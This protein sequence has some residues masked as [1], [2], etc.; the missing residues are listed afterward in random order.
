MSDRRP[1]VLLALLV[2][3][4]LLLITL[5]FREGEEGPLSELQRAAFD[6]FAPLQEAVAAITQPVTDLVDGVGE[7]RR[8]RE[9]IAQLEQELERVRQERLSEA[10]LRRENDELRELLDMRERR[11]LT[12]IT[13]R[14]IAQPPGGSRWSALLDVG[15]NDGVEPDMAV[16]NADG[17][18]GKVV[19]VAPDHARIKLAANPRARYAVRLASDGEQALLSGRGQRPMELQVIDDTEAELAAGTDV[20]TRAYQGTRI[21]DG[22]PVGQLASGGLADRRPSFPVEPAVD[23]SRLDLVMV[24]LDAPEVPADLDPADDVDVT[25][26]PPDPGSEPDEEGA[27]L[28]PPVAGRPGH[29]G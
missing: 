12:T 28:V 1:R 14:V 10:D 8:Q 26:S 24:V 2:L 9:R 19:R 27:A 5:D 29:R 17:L 7:F 25:P 6:A 23:F 3:V 11:E 13:S 16:I 22:L 4:A 18:V 21:P 20:V 15:A